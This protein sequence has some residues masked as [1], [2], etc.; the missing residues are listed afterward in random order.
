M[1]HKCDDLNIKIDIAAKLLQR[2]TDNEIIIQSL[3]LKVSQQVLFYHF[4]EIDQDDSYFPG[5]S[6]SNASKHRKEKVNSWADIIIKTV[7][8]LDGT[9]TSKN[10]ILLEFIQKVI[11]IFR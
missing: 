9:A 7:S 5:Y 3:A 10:T 4:H 2:I 6:F 8:K 1:Y 11:L